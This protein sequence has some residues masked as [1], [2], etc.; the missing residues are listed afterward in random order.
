MACSVFLPIARQLPAEGLFRGSCPGKIKTRSLNPRDCDAGIRE[1]PARVFPTSVA[2]DGRSRT[3]LLASLVIRT[4]ISSPQKWGQK[5]DGLIRLFFSPAKAFA[6]GSRTLLLAS[7]VIKTRFFP[8]R[9]IR[10][11]LRNFVTRFARNMVVAE[12]YEMRGKCEPLVLFYSG[13]RLLM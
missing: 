13:S 9:R 12:K 8:V 7:L 11:T 3:L 10:R 1:R 6:G 4:S 5:R 2:Y